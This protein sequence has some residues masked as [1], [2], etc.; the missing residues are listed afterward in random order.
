MLKLEQLGPNET[1]VHLTNAIILFSHNTP[2]AYKTKGLGQN[3]MYRTDRKFGVTASEH[4]NQWKDN[5]DVEIVPHSQIEEMTQYY[6][7]LNG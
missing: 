5:Y 7:E 6:S 2:V 3:I 1:E 4:I